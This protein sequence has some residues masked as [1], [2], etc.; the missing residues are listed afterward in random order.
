[1]LVRVRWFFVGW[2]ITPR[3]RAEGPAHHIRGRG[4][5]KERH[6][7]CRDRTSEHSVS[8]NVTDGEKMRE[9]Q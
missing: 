8:M 9:P 4:R 7:D 6:I 3:H 2:Q 5:A 1:M